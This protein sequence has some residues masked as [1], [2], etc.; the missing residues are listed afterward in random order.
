MTSTTSAEFEKV[1][2]IKMYVDDEMRAALNAVLDSKRYIKGEQGAEFEKEFAAFCEAKHALA[3]SSGTAAV[4]LCLAALGVKAGDE[5]IVP[6]HTFIATAS[7]AV[8]LGATPVF[9][10][11]DEETY[12]IDPVDVER[13]ITPK[14][15]AIVAVHLYGHPADM[16][17]LSAISKKRGIPIVEDSCQGHAAEFAGKRAGTLG[18]IAAFSFFPSKN[19]TVCG[20]GGMVVTDDSAL[21]E[22]VSM[23]RDAGRKPTEKYR[24]DLIGWNYRLSEVHASLGRVQL[25]HV[26]EFTAKRRKAA[27]RYDALLSDI[28]RDQL[29]RPLAPTQAEK[30][31]GAPKPVYHLYVVRPPQRDAL[32]AY[33]KTK[34]IETGIHYPLAVHQQPAMRRFVSSDLSLPVTERAAAQVLSLPMHPALTAE[35]QKRVSEAIHEFFQKL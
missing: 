24:H 12:C 3:V 11:I 25:K 33:L 10:D 14:T 2:L 28:P 31:R 27:E 9:A 21:A 13:K 15:K 8:L 26:A 17:T 1:Q 30:L 23:L 16:E 18:T 22:K 4:H 5:V 35:E 6:S 34:G 19:L 7:P 29:I 20:D 32:A